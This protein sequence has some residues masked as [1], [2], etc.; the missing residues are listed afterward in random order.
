MN[1]MAP[2]APTSHT[3]ARCKASTPGAAVIDGREPPA[4]AAYAITHSRKYDKLR[5]SASLRAQ[6]S[7]PSFPALRYGLLRCAR[8]DGEV[9]STNS[10]RVLVLGYQRQRRLEQNVEVEQHRPV[11]D[12]IEV[13]LDTLLDLLVGIDLAAPAVDLRPA[14]DARL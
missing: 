3:I 13:E 5:H 9:L 10:V 11:L 12:V 4:V 7:N 2:D 8:N 1:T 14:G 6:R